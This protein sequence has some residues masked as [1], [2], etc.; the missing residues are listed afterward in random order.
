MDMEHSYVLPISREQA[1][2][3]LLDLER[4]GQCMPGLVLRSVEGDQ[5][6]GTFKFKVGP[7]R[8][9]YAGTA[10]LVE[11]DKASGVMLLKASA[12]ETRGAGRATATIRSVLEDRGHE[13]QVVVQTTLNITGK[14][15]Q[16]GRGVMNEIGGKL[17]REFAANL[18][19]MIA[20]DPAGQS[21]QPQ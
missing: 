18:A 9:A 19:A 6:T 14:P 7:I 13:T 1:W 8:L 17:V 12:D 4:A 11:K 15:A 3:V 2:D 10:H 21:R 20:A 5:M 16:F